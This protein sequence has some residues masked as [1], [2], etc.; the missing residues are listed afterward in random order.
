MVA[1]TWHRSHDPAPTSSRSLALEVLWQTLRRA[2]LFWNPFSC[3]PDRHV[4]G[5]RLSAK[6]ICTFACSYPIYYHKPQQCADVQSPA[7]DSQ[8]EVNVFHPRG[9]RSLPLPSWNLVEAL[10]AFCLCFSLSGAEPKLTPPAMGFV[11]GKLAAPHPPPLVTLAFCSA[12]CHESGHSAASPARRHPRPL[13]MAFHAAFV[14]CPPRMGPE[15]W[16]EG[17]TCIYLQDSL[18]RL[19]LWKVSKGIKVVPTVPKLYLN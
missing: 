13:Q 5:A 10:C 16:W 7:W 14:D 2:K 1:S 6:G 3:L 15:S 17:N 18:Q 12:T 8:K 11:C 4:F 9:R 19:Q